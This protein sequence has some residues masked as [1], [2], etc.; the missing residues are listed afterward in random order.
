L[1]HCRFWLC[2][3]LPSGSLAGRRPSPLFPNRWSSFRRPPRRAP[4]PAATRS[5][6]PHTP[7]T[8]NTQPHGRM[9]P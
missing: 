8:A 9:N 6:A 4:R 7:P 2:P 3:L 5:L 1:H